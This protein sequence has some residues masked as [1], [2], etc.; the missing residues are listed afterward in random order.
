MGK[1]SR[2]EMTGLTEEQRI[3]KGTKQKKKVDAEK[4]KQIARL[5]M[6]KLETD[7]KAREQLLEAIRKS[8]K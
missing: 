1:R 4:A 5:I 2:R 3:E 8:K 6:Y 7:L